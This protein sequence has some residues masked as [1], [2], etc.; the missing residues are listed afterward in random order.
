MKKAL[1]V[2]GVI[3]SFAANSWAANGIEIA[4]KGGV[5]DNFSYPG[6][7]L[8][9]D[10]LKKEGLIGAHL[11][12]KSPP[13][14]DLIV[15]MDYTW[16]EKNYT[17]AGQSFDFKTRD[18]T[19]SASLVYPMTLS[20]ARFYAGG[21]AGTHSFSHEYFRPRSISLESNGVKIPE[22]A[23]YFGYH[24]IAGAK[25]NLPSI[26]CGLFVESR[27]GRINLPDEDISYNNWTG[28][29]Y[30]SFP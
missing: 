11:Y 7:I 4:L 19:V 18:I 20:F 3:L 26:P 27:V 10:N 22:I 24:A 23:T 2:F 28:G 14:I 25:F 17:I 1:I 9:K 13:V 16:Q 21:G 30:F 8:P 5:V 6:L 12:I 29:I 15:S